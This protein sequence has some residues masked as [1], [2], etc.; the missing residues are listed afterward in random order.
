MVLTTEKS[1]DNLYSD[2]VSLKHLY[3]SETAHMPYTAL[4]IHMYMV[5]AGQGV[6]DVGIPLRAME[7]RG[8]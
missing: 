2:L 8:P 5:T 1:G 6:E 7:S 3:Q 4:R